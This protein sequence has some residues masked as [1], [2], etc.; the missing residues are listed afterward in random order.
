MRDLTRKKQQE[1]EA[2]IRRGA[3]MLVETAEES[4]FLKWAKNELDILNRT[5]DSSSDPDL[6]EEQ[7]RM[8]RVYNE[9]FAKDQLMVLAAFHACGHSGFSASFASGQLRRLFNWLPLTP[10]TGDDSE[11]RPNTLSGDHSFQNKR[12]PR[13]FRGNDGAYSLDVYAFKETDDSPSYT[14]RDSWENIE[15]PYWPK[16]TTVLVLNGRTPKEAI[17]AYKQENKAG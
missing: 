12:C 16:P 8:D 5:D 13:V 14:C 1:A 4:P 17:E 11:W 7:R 3:E 9:A 15:F 6:T 2:L 10:L